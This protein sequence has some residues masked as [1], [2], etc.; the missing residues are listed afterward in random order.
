M[1]SKFGDRGDELV[2][3]YKMAKIGDIVGIEQE[4]PRLKDLDPTYHGF[5]D[6]ILTLASEFE[7]TTIIQLIQSAPS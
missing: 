7:D 5:C 1:R 2:K 3:L 6:R 4:A